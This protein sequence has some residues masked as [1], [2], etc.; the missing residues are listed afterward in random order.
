M[1]TQSLI[2]LID[3][4][5]LIEREDAGSTREPGS[6]RAEALA[7]EVA[8]RIAQIENV[9]DKTNNHAPLVDALYGEET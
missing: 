6:A 1:T 7:K 9:A 3:E 5:R 2:A 8:R 4:L